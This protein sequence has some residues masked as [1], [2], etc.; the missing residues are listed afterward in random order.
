MLVDAGPAGE[1]VTQQFT[2]VDLSAPD[3]APYEVANIL[4]RHELAAVISPDQAAQAHHDLADLPI[5]LWPYGA[6]A[7]RAWKLRHNLSIYDSAYVAL[8]EVLGATLVTLDRRIPRAP[9]ARCPVVAPPADG[10][11]AG[12]KPTA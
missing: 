4:R 11:D 10:G 2:D 6:L 5:G 7:D 3:L 9:G 12:V 1:W 8:A